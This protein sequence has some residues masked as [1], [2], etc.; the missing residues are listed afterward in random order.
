MT[1]NPFP[2]WKEKYEKMG[3]TPFELYMRQNGLC[4]L[5]PDISQGVVVLHCTD[6]K[7]KAETSKMLNPTFECMQCVSRFTEKVISDAVQT[8]RK[9]S[10][11]ESGS[12]NP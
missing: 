5:V 6:G 12:D 8:S 11:E 2:I 10:K 7:D 9:D 1:D 3:I 4:W